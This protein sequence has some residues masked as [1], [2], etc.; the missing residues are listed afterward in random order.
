[1]NN[2]SIADIRRVAGPL[3]DIEHDAAVE[4]YRATAAPGFAF[5]AGE[6]HELIST[7][8]H[9]DGGTAAEARAD[10]FDRLGGNGVS[11]ESVEPCP[12]CRAGTCDWSGG[13][14]ARPDRVGRQLVRW[15]ER[16]AP[17]HAG[18]FMGYG[19]Q[20]EHVRVVLRSTGSNAGAGWSADV[21]VD[22]DVWCA[23]GDRGGLRAARAWVREQ[24]RRELGRDLQW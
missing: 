5:H 17:L 8:G 21:H 11:A 23:R 19:P 3:I 1:M 12:A 13:E 24:L 20:R 10:L 4:T 16:G 14:P 22:R 6:L 15:L 2:P 18:T 7:Y 9:L